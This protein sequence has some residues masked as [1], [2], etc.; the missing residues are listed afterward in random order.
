MT[1]TK[2]RD[3]KQDKTAGGCRCAD[4]GKACACGP[5]CACAACACRGGCSR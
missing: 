1:T 4:G 3:E 5:R 2:N